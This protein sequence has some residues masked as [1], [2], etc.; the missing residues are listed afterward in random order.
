[1]VFLQIVRVKHISALPPTEGG[2]TAYCPEEIAH[3]LLFPHT[4]CRLSILDLFLGK[5]LG[6]FRRFLFDDL[7]SALGLHNLEES[8]RSHWKRLGGWVLVCA[9]KDIEAE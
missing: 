4:M 2:F 9:Q 5:F 1:M 6:S 7:G 3:G 8:F